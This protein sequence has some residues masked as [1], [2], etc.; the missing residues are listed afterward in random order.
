MLFC[1][2]AKCCSFRELSVAM[3]GLSG[4][5]KHFQLNHITKRSWAFSNR[6]S[7][8]KTHR[9]YYHQ[10]IIFLENT[11][12]DWRKILYLAIQPALFD[13]VYF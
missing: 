1:A 6:V 12:N 11:D 5:T 13:G 7:F 10:L 4:N 3:Q 9:F 2:L 8:C